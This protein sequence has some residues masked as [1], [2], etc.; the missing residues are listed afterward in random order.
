M[1]DCG[2]FLRLRVPRGV[3]Q[4]CRSSRS[5]TLVVIEPSSGATRRPGV[6]SRAPRPLRPRR[7]GRPLWACASGAK[8]RSSSS[9]SRA[10]ASGCERLLRHGVPLGAPRRPLRRRAPRTPD[11]GRKRP[12]LLLAC[13]GS[14]PLAVRR[15]RVVAPRFGPTRWCRRAAAKARRHP[16][17]RC[18][19]VFGRPR[20]FTTGRSSA[21]GVG[22]V[23]AS[24]ISESASASGARSATTSLGSVWRPAITRSLRRRGGGGP[25]GVDRRTRSD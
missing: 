17:Q 18:R 11:E 16:G 9:R 5:D 21:T 23:A 25:S 13:A 7:A 4:A 24:R 10:D 2:P 3:R 12:R 1:P 22:P 19:V 8:S 14:R 6:R 15:L 20:A